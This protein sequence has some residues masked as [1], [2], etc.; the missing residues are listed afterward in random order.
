[1]IL[2]RLGAAIARQDWFV[3]IIE[4]AVLVL[5]IFIG[6]QVDDWNRARKDRVDEQGFLHALHDDILVAEELSNR[7]RKRRLEKLTYIVSASDVLHG[8]A[9][10]NEL[11][12]SECNAIGTSSWINI[13]A[14]GLSAFDE[15]VASG[16]LGIVRDGELRAAL[17]GLRQSHQALATIRVP[18]PMVGQ[19]RLL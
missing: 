19:R 10:R 11:T 12:E 14:S 7:L 2:G 17:I 16:R 13:T 18:E 5:G 1:M 9:K 15:L 4:L 3:I 8:R 6:L